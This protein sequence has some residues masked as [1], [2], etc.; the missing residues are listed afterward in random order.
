MAQTV[1]SHTPKLT[2]AENILLV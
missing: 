2:M 1:L